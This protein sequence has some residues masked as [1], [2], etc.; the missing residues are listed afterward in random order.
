MLQYSITS[1]FLQLN[2]IYKL[3]YYK[4]I[5][6]LYHTSPVFTEFYIL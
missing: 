6:D 1:M 3:Y 4:K 2:L 5:Q